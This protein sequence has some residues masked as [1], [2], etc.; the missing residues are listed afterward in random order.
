MSQSKRELRAQRRSEREAAEQAAAAAT[1]R[2]RRAWRLAAAAGLAAIVVVVGVAVSASGGDP[3]PAVK[4]GAADVVKGIPER[5]GVLGDPKA[6]LTV[7]E[8]VDLQCPVCAVAS[9]QTLP[10]LI[11]DYVRTG[12]VKLQARTL[13]FLGPD[14]VRAAK[15]AAGAEQQGRQWAFLESF[16][17]AQGSEN[18]GYVTD[19]FLRSVAEVAG[20]DA[21][22]ALEYATT[23]GAQDA[24]DRADQDAQAVGAD[25]TPTFT[26]RRGDGPETVIA[27]GAQDAATLAA[28]LDKALA[29]K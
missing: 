15:V 2:R 27:T 21:E 20:V 4:A 6:P 25:S 3:A 13:S 9:E 14:S 8:Y 1:T 18:S 28:A 7:T 5:A 26:V 24:L 22:A 29:A 19:D 11:D 10:T 12:K 17:A 23:Q 16:Y